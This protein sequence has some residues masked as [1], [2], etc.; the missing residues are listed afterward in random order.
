MENRVARESREI[1]RKNERRRDKSRG[2][3][4]W[5]TEDCA[6]RRARGKDLQREGE[7]REKM[8]RRGLRERATKR[9]EHGRDAK[10]GLR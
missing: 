2:E 1:K 5:R 8:A 9:M 4:K 7:G 10:R 6:E 3:T